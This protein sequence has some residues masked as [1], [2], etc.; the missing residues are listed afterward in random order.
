M[1]KRHARQV[2]KTTKAGFA[3]FLA[4]HIVIRIALAAVLAAGLALILY[5][6]WQSYG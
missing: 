1:A 5:R 3:L 4:Q 6:I 2:T